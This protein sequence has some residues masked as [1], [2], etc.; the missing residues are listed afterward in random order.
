MAHKY[1]LSFTV[2]DVVIAEDIDDAWGKFKERLEDRFYGP[3]VRDITDLGPVS[4]EE[5]E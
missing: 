5:E 2:E 3:T 4:P 1:G